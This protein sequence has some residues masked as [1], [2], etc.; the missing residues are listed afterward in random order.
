MEKKKKNR[1]GN[2]PY[3]TIIIKLKTF[4]IKWNFSA[5]CMDI[6]YCR[7]VCMYVCCVQ[8]CLCLLLF[9]WYDWSRADMN[10][11]SDDRIIK[12]SKSWEKSCRTNEPKCEI[13]KTNHLNDVFDRNYLMEF[14]W[15]AMDRK[16]FNWKMYH[17]GFLVFPMPKLSLNSQFRSK[18]VRMS[19]FKWIP[20]FKILNFN[21]NFNCV[22]KKK[23]KNLSDTFLAYW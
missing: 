19:Q 20:S 13:W 7:C 14:D 1:I 17:D 16:L 15:W 5:S 6:V 10:G 4:Y 23:K 18:G 3:K 21:R 12:W 22:A 2:R 9:L 8:V 11:E